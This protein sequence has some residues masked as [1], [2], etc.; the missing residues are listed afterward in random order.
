MSN[1]KRFYFILLGLA[2]FFIGQTATAQSTPSRTRFDFDGDRKADIGVFRPSNGTWYLNRSRDGFFAAQFGVS[3]DQTIAAD[4]DG[5]GNTDIAVFRKFADSSWYILQSS[6]NTFRAANWGATN[7][8]QQLLIQFEVPVPGDYDADGKTDLAVW[9]LTD[10]LSEPARFLILRSSDNVG[11]STQW[12]GFGDSVVAAADY[13]GDSKADITIRRGN[14]WYSLL[15][16]TN[17]VRAVTFGAADDKA[18]PADY[19]A[20]GKADVAVFRPSNG[21][22]YLNR[23]NLGFTGIAFG[24]NGDVPVPADYD[25][26]GKTDLAV[27]RN[28]TWYLL[29]SQAGLSSVSFG[30]SDDKPI[31]MVLP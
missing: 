29:Q 13:D 22:W 17:A 14:V 11:Y 24:Q 5:D 30:A 9:R 7:F 16:Q 19:D 20:D 15:S 18:V 2:V 4:Y 1:G 10:N 8:E 23:T 6:N 26:D 12:G 28:G 21:A 31:S 27:F 25:A 3:N